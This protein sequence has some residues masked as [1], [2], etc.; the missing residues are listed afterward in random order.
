MLQVDYLC[1][2]KTLRN[3]QTNLCTDETLR[4][5]QTL[6]CPTNDFLI[7]HSTIKK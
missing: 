2:E 4:N 6:F 5:I 3:I 7:L 1:T